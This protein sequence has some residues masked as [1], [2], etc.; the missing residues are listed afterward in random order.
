MNPEPQEDVARNPTN[1]GNQAPRGDL[2][3]HI[4]G[5]NSPL[6]WKEGG[7]LVW[8]G[9]KESDLRNQGTFFG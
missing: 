2:R 6:V 1:P 3:R 9:G 8:G 5:I 4:W 7:G